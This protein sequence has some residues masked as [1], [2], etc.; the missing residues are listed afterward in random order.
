MK[1]I[2]LD[3][4]DIDIPSAVFDIVNALKIEGYTPYLVGGCVR[5]ILLGRNPKDFDIVSNALPNDVERIF[6][7]TKSVGKFF[8]VILVTIGNKT[9]EVSTFRKDGQY[10]DGRHP[11][12]IEF[13]NIETDANRRDFTCNGLFYDV[14]KKE[15]FDFHNGIDD[16]KNKTLRTIGNANERITEDYLRM[17]RA[18]RFAAGLDFNINNSLKSAISSAAS[19]IKNISEERIFEEINRM[20][21]GKNAEVS[22]RLMDEFG[23]LP[24]LLPEITMMKNIPQGEDYHPE[25][26]VFEHTM[27]ILSKFPDDISLPIAWGALLHDV[28][29][30]TT[31]AIT[32]R[33]RFTQHETIGAEMAKNILKRFK[34]SNDLI[35]IVYRIVRDHM[36][37]INVRSMKKSTLRR[38]IGDAD[39]RSLLEVHRIDALASNNNLKYYDFCIRFLDEYKI[40]PVKPMP[41]L[42]GKHLI[43]MGLEPSP[44][45]KSILDDVYDL[46]LEGNIRT[47]NEA[48]A[49]VHKKYNYL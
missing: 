20:L 19:M 4:D 28:A 49:Y 29:K 22:F 46:Q 16:I 44:I 43:E 11:E 23:L 17:L 32:D 12:N 25:G 18:V 37:F 40:E 45:F 26:D 35:D 2:M 8:G 10:I 47:I 3:T 5:D 14:I 9:F 48:I 1:T 39:F 41:I 36:K 42:K 24:I 33:I 15:I 21:T 31:F 27:T 7:N 38:F 13:G 30:P 6:P 34:A